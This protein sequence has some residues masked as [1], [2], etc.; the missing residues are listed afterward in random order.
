[1]FK[2]IKIKDQKNPH[3]IVNVTIEISNSDATLTDLLEA[4]ESFLMA[5]GYSLGNRKLEFIEPD[6]P[7]G[8]E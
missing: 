2:F 6:E 4:F 1:M 8:V 3:D 5:S 7:E